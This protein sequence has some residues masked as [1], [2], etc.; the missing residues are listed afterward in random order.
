MIPQLSDRSSHRPEPGPTIM[1]MIS[2][3]AL[4]HD[5]EHYSSS[6]T[7]STTRSSYM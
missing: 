1:I 3:G 6:R 2:R 7:R 5:L 4:I